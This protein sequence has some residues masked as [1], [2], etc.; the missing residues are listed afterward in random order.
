[1]PVPA[2]KRV[3]AMRKRR[4][5]GRRIV[6]VEVDKDLIDS[7]VPRFLKPDKRKDNRGS[8][9]VCRSGCGS[10]GSMG[11][12]RRAQ[13]SGLLGALIWSTLA[14]TRPAAPRRAV[15]QKSRQMRYQR[16]AALVRQSIFQ[17]SFAGS[18]GGIGMER[19]PSQ[20]MSLP[21]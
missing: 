9:K 8:V 1:M 10:R 11:A 18:A 20:A 15:A 13:P 17:S 12:G 21:K 19:Q 6:P 14:I 16:V 4:I 2:A 7:L 5:Y 3:K